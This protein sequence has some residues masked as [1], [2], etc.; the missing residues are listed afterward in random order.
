M[1]QDNR[2]M[3]M[4]AVERSLD[5]PLND[6][7]QVRSYG[8]AASEPNQL[9]D[10]LFVVLKRKWLI[11]SLCLVITSLVAV[12]MFRQP[13]IYEA[14]ATIRIEQRAKNVLQ[15]KDFVLNAQPD[16]NFWGTQ[17]KLLQS[18]ALARQ[19][20]LSLDLQHNS[21]FFGSQSQGGI[22]AALRRMVSG[23]KK[24]ATRPAAAP[25]SLEVIG[26][27]RLRDDPLTPEELSALEPYEDAIVANERVEGI[28]G[29]N[30]FVI[31]YQ[32]IDPEMAQKVANALADVFRANNVER[33]TQNSTKAE[34]LLAREI[35]SLQDKIRYDTEAL[36]N[37]ARE[38]GLPPTMDPTL[39]VEGQRLSDLSKQVL[40]AENKRKQA[41]AVYVN[42]KNTTDPYSIP[43]VQKSGR[44]ASLQERI[45]ELKEKKAALKVTYTDEWPD[46]KKADV[47][48]KRLES[49]LEKAVAETVGMLKAEADAA[50]DHENRIRDMYLKQRGTTDQQTRDQIMMAEYSQRLESNK[51]NL[52][53]LLQRQREVQIAS[54][55]T[56]SEVNVENY[57][58]VPRS[59]VGPA[60][61]R[62]VLIAFVLSL[63]AGI[64]LAFLLDFLDDT[65]K[66]LDDVD[67]YIHLPALAMIPAGDHRGPR[68]K[69][70]PQANAGPSESTALAMVD[71]VR[72]PIAESYRHLRTSLLLSSAGQP[73]RTILV[74]SSQPSE[75]KTTTAINTAFMLAQ[76]GAEVLIIDC[77]LRRPRLHT[78]FEVANSRGL[79]TWLSGEKDLDN[80]LQ[81]Y[82]KTPNLK[83]LTSGPVPPNP[84]ELLGSE[85][86][87]RLLG[88]LS[89]RFAHIIIDSPPAISFTDASILSTMVD[90]VMLVVHGGRSSRAVVRRAKQQLLDVGAHIFGVVLNNV[91]VES[92]DYYYSGYYSNYYP[93]EAD[94]GRDAS[95]GQTA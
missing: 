40:D 36:F 8:P 80:L 66:S 15:T 38:K 60:R 10:Y 72:S 12:Q 59:P 78:Q 51:Q 73:P 52:N 82:P 85:E 86:M 74:T 87:R 5:R 89:E 25:G 30:L 14:Q 76:T 19:V 61:M 16:A 47:A 2:L 9:R 17:I 65:V 43:D 23:D 22:F 68:L 83:I 57:S 44:I 42:A 67:R 41:Q 58:R 50:Q 7:G 94:G 55:D 92:Q 34:D 49:D 84:A 3:S 56:G 95:A 62:N 91:K 93:T 29:T 79:T 71:D 37:Y 24:P 69:G 13:A 88:L 48:I 31:K 70:L 26:Q 81:S 35:A 39:N 27:A 63:G 20:A 53:T 33:V 11:L 21:T 75:G 6:I 45:S 28:P 54:G 64:G 18:P 77:D 90:G 4:P 1:S 46:V 32:H